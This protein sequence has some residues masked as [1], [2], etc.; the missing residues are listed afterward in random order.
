MAERRRICPDNSVMIPAFFPEEI[1]YRGNPFDTTRRAKPLADAIRAA[2]VDAYAPDQL[3]YEFT[4]IAYRKTTKGISV[5]QAT[6]QLQWF[7]H[8][9]ITRVPAGEIED[10]AWE[11]ITEHGISPPDSWYL[12]CAILYDAELWIQSREQ[13]DHFGDNAWAIHD[14]VFF[15]TEHRFDKP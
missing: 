3:V 5:E 6:E 2:S 13:R 4:K 12:A 9:R 15:L 10:K 14:R 7:R 11:L 1:N 8:L